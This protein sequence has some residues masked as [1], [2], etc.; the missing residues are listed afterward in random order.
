MT[1]QDNI[2]PVIFWFRRDLRL[3]DNT[4]LIQALKTGHPVLP[5]FIFDSN[6]LQ[7]LADASDKR[8][9]FIHQEVSRLKT[10]LESQYDTSL[11]PTSS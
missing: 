11:H 6:I 9:Q 8:V 5:V 10:E 3:E 2:R 7:S 4:G 1:S